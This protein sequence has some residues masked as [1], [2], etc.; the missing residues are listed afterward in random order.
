MALTLPHTIDYAKSGKSK[1]DY[2]DDLYAIFSHDFQT[3]ITTFLGQRVLPHRDPITDG[4][5]YS[6][7]HIV[8]FDVSKVGSIDYNRCKKI[9]WL[10]PILGGC[11]VPDVKCWAIESTYINKK[12][13]KKRKIKRIKVWYEA[14]NLLLILEQKGNIYYLV[15]AYTKAGQRSIDDLNDEYTNSSTKLY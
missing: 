6:F 4:R 10:S 8:K 12:T 3:N 5:V 13:K 2:L 7:N 15:T 11:P 14:G 9:P 1:N